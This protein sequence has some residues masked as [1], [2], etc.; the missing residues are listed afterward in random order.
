IQQETIGIPQLAATSFAKVQN[1]GRSL[2]LT[3]YTN[4]APTPGS[5]LAMNPFSAADTRKRSSL[6]SLSSSAYRSSR[7]VIGSAANSHGERSVTGHDKTP[8]GLTSQRHDELTGVTPEL[9]HT[10][11]NF[12]CLRA[13]TSVIPPES[14]PRPTVSANSSP[15]L[16]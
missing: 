11:T 15:L 12:A 14:R 7:N 3:A 2:C 13:S 5:P 10:S 4:N 1:C 6:Y 9:N 8:P 16:I